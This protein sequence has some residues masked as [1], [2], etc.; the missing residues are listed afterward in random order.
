MPDVLG[1]LAMKS[2]EDFEAEVAAAFEATYGT[3]YAG[4]F[5]PIPGTDRIKQIEAKCSR[6]GRDY[7]VR[8]EH[9]GKTPMCHSCASLRKP[10]KRGRVNA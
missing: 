3:K 10:S 9:R 1:E 4:S 5:Y 7:W 8:P 6:C 2:Q